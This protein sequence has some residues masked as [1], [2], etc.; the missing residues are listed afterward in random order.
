MTA[1]PTVHSRQST[2]AAQVIVQQ[3][4]DQLHRRP[5]TICGRRPG[6]AG[7]IGHFVGDGARRIA[8]YESLATIGEFAGILTVGAWKGNL[9]C[10][11]VSK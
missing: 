1:A 6:K 8:E 11:V 9:G 10:E 2:A 4:V 3:R 7:F 5:R